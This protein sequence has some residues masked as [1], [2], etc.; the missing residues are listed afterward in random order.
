MRL[1][2]SWLV[3]GLAL[4]AGLSLSAQS[5]SS[6]PNRKIEGDWVR[7]DLEASGSFAALN[8]K[9]APAQLLP[10]VSMPGRG[11]GGGRA[12]GA[13]GGVARGGALNAG[14]GPNP[15][16]VP[17]IVVAQ[18]CGGGGGG[19]GNGALLINP[20]SGGIH[21]IEHKGEVIFAGERG[22]VRHIY[23]DGRPHPSVG[24][25][26]PTGAG[27]SVGHYE[28]DVL[29]VDTTGLTQGTVVAGG[30][31]TPETHLVERFEVQPDGKRMTITY[32]WDDPKVY[33]K[34]HTYTY[35]FDRAPE[36]G[37][38]SYAMEEWC[39]A[40]DP[41]EQQSIVPPAQLK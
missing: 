14:N 31:R 7:L 26:T 33:A 1:H 2:A 13:R 20:D 15:V 8:S 22:G 10:G 6:T 12:G 25:R 23:L 38:A 35:T 9:V 37:G 28:G 4:C 18:P 41:I 29:V 11:G 24:N 40:G 39:D 19:R 34:P 16:G 36:I 30:I 27:H 21:I 5:P 17:Y 32:T 3:Y